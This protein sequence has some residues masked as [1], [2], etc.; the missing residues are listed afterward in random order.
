[1]T[2]LQPG[3]RAPYDAGQPSTSETGPD[4]F[5]DAGAAVR[6]RMPHVE[7]PSAPPAHQLAGR[8][9]VV[10]WVVLALVALD[11]LAVLLMDMWLLESLGHE[12]VFWTNFWTRVVLA[13][14]GAAIVLA[15]VIT[16]FLLQRPGPGPGAIRRAISVGL[17]LA[18]IGGWLLS[19]HYLTFL[20]ARHGKSFGADDPVFGHDIGFYVFTLPA[21]RVVWTAL[22]LGAA[23]A[24]VA[25]ILASWVSTRTDDDHEA[26]TRL[27]L[28]T[29]VATGWSRGAVAVT[30]V[31]LAVGLFLERYGVLTRDN[32]ESSIPTGAQALDVSGPLST[33]T[34]L[35]TSAVVVLIAT[36][37]V[38]WA[39]VPGRRHVRVVVWLVSGLLVLDFVGYRALLAV[40][41]MVGVNA[42]EPVVQLPY[43]ERHLTATRAAWGLDRVE[44]VE[45]RPNGGDD[46]LPSLQRIL[47][48]ASVESAG[49]WP[50]YS[51]RLE[52]L[53]DPEYVERLFL[54]EGDSF[55]E[56]YNT[57]LDAFR[58]QQKLRPYY[59]F[60]DVDTVRYQIDG[61]PRLLASAVR[62]VPLLEPQPWLAWWG[63]RFV[64]F[65][66][67]FG[68]VASDMSESD[69]SGR[70]ALLSSGI[71]ARAEGPLIVDNERVYYGEGSGTMAYSNLADI[72]ELDRPTD[73]GR[74][75]TRLPDDVPAGVHLDSP[76]KRLVF[77]WKSGELASIT[78]SDLITD[79]SRVHYFREPLER[80]RKV[81]PFLYLE[82]DPY[83]VSS[84][85]DI[86]WMVNALTVAR[87]YPYS[88]YADLG[89]KSDRRSP[90]A[91]DSASVNYA[92][93]TV[94][95]TVNG[96]SGEV[97]LYRI[98]DEPVG[99][100]WA[101]VY[102]DLFQP[103]SA[104]PETLREHVQYPTQLFHAQFDD[105]FVYYHVP[106]AITFFNAEDLWDDSD[107]V[108]GPVLS[109]G[110]T[111]TFSMEPY[112]WIAETGGN[113]RLPGDAP[114]DTFALS[115][116]FTPENALN[117]RAILTAYQD[118]LDDDY[119]RLVSLE[120]PKSEFHPSPEQADA[121]ID[122]DA[123]I[124]QQIG[125]WNRQGNQIIRGH[126]MPLLVD[127]ELIYVEP[128]F[129]RSAQNP[130]PQLQ[131]VVV[132]VRGRPSIGLDLEDALRVA[133][134]GKQPPG[135]Q[136]SPSS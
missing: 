10:S 120:V 92:A 74:E 88:A 68:L 108:V 97:G 85:E 30:G 9:L 51:S 84:G 8:L 78:F 80:L 132:V 58:Q 104:M 134:A 15:A 106:D 135:V 29:A 3:A 39:L 125:F 111:V 32:Y 20:A 130:A 24:V 131:R 49:L 73:Q 4:L 66:H 79:T 102:P 91:T 54:A 103:A 76:L 121:A 82:T 21:V 37:A 101:A 123:F 18:V 57:T 12:Q 59:D 115:M 19:R 86:T 136:A 118:G 46:P 119:G 81:A 95:A 128:I 75:E 28:R 53:L 50:G 129:S 6:N 44:S 40:R 7:L 47:S 1:M 72:N 34:F 27:R 55:D 98:A 14:G 83:A 61:E 64:L 107:E 94:K 89:D 33:V 93:D 109:E 16:P 5:A 105:L 117:L 23:L 69:Q 17:F 65:T 62:E 41:E 38:V 110:S 100:T 124:S 42:N 112:P 70:P 133:L 71:P 52:R 36:V 26:S 96:Y 45:L 126:T 127:G 60:M 48:S 11:R 90:G 2:T 56:I 113:S 25:G 43:I 67:G 35:T 114:D 77:G 99:A 122:Q 13:A 87:D 63:Q 22:L 116:V 31:L